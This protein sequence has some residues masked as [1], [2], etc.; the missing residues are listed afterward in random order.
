WW[1]GGVQRGGGTASRGKD[2]FVY[3]PM[4]LGGG[5]NVEGT[6]PKKKTAALDQTFAVSIGKDGLVYHTEPLPNETPFVGCPALTLW[7][8]IDTPDVDLEC[9][10]YEIQPDGASIALWSD[11][12]RLRYRESLRGAKLVQPGEIVRC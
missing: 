8:S 12:R 6:D 10:L 1:R 2:A 9:D 7:V 11:V 3:D 5:E 4:D